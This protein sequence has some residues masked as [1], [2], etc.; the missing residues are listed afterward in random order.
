MARVTAIIPTLC[1]SERA[2]RLRRAIASLHASSKESLVIVLVLNGQ[3]ADPGLVSEMRARP[4]IRVEQISHASAPLAQLHGRRCVQTD[5]FCFLDD[6]D[7]Y[8]PGA[9][10]VRL[11]ALDRRPPCDLVITNGFRRTNDGREVLVFDKLH[12][13]Q[14]DPL[15]TLAFQNW[16]SSC[17]GL[18]RTSS[19]PASF[20]ENHLNYI[21]WTWFAFK[22]A[23][24]NKS[25]HVIEEPTFRIHETVGSLSRSEPYMFAQ[26]ELYERML[27]SIP[28]QRADMY[29]SIMEK[30]CHAWHGISLHHLQQGHRLKAWS[31]HIR[32]LRHPIG[33]RYASYTRHLLF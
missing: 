10:D 24:A 27:A 23:L 8:L 30:M 33:W 12:E 7:E 4:D 19:I 28:N 26:I 13:A 31:A 17:G 32:S 21:E 16:M 5:F 25:L 15:G 20:F 9:I 29:R 11:A 22:L 1:S 3:R 6:D 2:E 14:V 18:F